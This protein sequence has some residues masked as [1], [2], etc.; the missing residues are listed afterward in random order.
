MFAIAIWY[1]P[2]NYFKYLHDGEVYEENRL[3]FVS[4]EGHNEEA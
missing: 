2:M 4:P 3:H 1:A